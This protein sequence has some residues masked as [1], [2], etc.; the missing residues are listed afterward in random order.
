M[1][2]GGSCTRTCSRFEWLQKYAEKL[3][4]ESNA[5]RVQAELVPLADYDPDENLQDETAVCVFVLSTYEGGMPPE[6]A[7]WFHKWLDR[8]LP[9]RNNRGNLLEMFLFVRSEI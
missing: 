2:A 9:Q 3:V 5:R 6:G 8:K 4:K 1:G 7:R